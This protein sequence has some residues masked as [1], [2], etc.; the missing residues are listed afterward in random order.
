MLKAREFEEK[1]PEK[2]QAGINTKSRVLITLIYALFFGA[3]SGVIITFALSFFIPEFYTEWAGS[4]VCSGKIEYV[5]L[6]Q[7]YF[8]YT[9]PNDYFDLGDAMFWALFKRFIIP[10]IAVCFLLALGFVKLGEFF[11]QRKEAAGF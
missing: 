9:S 2:K 6:K 11:Y 3:L 1:Q 4:F 8:C 5:K 7:T 10:A